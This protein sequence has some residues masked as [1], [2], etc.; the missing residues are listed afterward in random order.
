MSNS[1]ITVL[2]GLRKITRA[3]R[4]ERSG[5][6]HFILEDRPRQH[7]FKLSPHLSESI[8]SVQLGL[9]WITII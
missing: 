6:R 4:Q 1:K 7:L 2:V 3:T 5:L 9:S 8:S